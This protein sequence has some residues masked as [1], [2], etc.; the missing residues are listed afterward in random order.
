M[1]RDEVGEWE[2]GRSKRIG[3]EE[4]PELND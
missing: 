1:G 2:N 3:E 4:N